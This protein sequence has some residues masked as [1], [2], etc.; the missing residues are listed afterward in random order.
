MAENKNQHFVPR[1]YLS[2][3]SFNGGAQTNLIRINELKAVRGIGVAGQCQ[4]DYFYGKNL[5]IEKALGTIEGT[6]RTVVANVLRT[7]LL[8]PLGTA[9]DAILKTFVCIQ[10]IRTR[11]FSES[12]DSGFSEM[13]KAKF[14]E[15]FKA[16]GLTDADMA[17][18]QIHRTEG[19]RDSV[20]QGVDFIP[21]FWDLEAKLVLS[22]GLGEF[23]T[24]D[25][26][27]VLLNPHY[28]GR[29]DGGVTGVALDG[30]V[31]LFPLS[32]DCLL[33]LYDNRCYRVGA[34]GKSAVPLGSL[35]DLAALN[36]HLFLH[37]DQCVYHRDSA[38]AVRHVNEFAQVKHLR[39]SDRQIVRE[40]PQPDGG[41]V[42]HTFTQPILYQPDVVFMKVLRHRRHETAQVGQIPPRDP[43][44]SNH[45]ASYTKAVNAKSSPRG[46]ASYIANIANTVLT[47]AEKR[48]LDAQMVG[49]KPSVDSHPKE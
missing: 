43:A 47:D 10:W 38:Q 5:K 19:P 18:V 9:A 29:F 2:N 39:V 26:P 12:F 36:N 17:D 27:V 3:F 41:T 40:I 24:S 33:I 35:G 45:F 21:F 34:A 4:D 14:R 49:H 20:A 42:L 1:F 13:L 25:N 28:L 37:A 44:L 6:S 8:P 23:V 7:G 32:P 48:V 22:N 15:D 11:E 30:T 16:K 46:F 31:V